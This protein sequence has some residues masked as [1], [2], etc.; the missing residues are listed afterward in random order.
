MTDKVKQL[1]L[2]LTRHDFASVEEHMQFCTQNIRPL[3]DEVRHYADGLEGEATNELC[4]YPTYQE[5]L[6]IK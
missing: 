3:L 5:M 1:S 6:F 4:P 2:A